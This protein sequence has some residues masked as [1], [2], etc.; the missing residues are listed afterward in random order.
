MRR[1]KG[2]SVFWQYDGRLVDVCN[3]RLQ[4]EV[5]IQSDLSLK[6]TLIFML[7]KLLIFSVGLG[8]YLNPFRLC[9]LLWVVHAFKIA[10]FFLI[11]V[12]EEKFFFF[13]SI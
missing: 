10:R 7:G 12:S 6:V 4:I 11:E 13:K 5:C 2:G 8:G 3:E 9:D 1:Q